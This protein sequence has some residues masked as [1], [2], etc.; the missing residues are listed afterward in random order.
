M[1]EY[2]IAHHPDFNQ[3]ILNIS[4]ISVIWENNC[5]PE[6]EAKVA[7][8][9]PKCVIRWSS[10]LVSHEYSTLSE[11]LYSIGVSLSESWYWLQYT[12]QRS[13]SQS[14][15]VICACLCG[16]LYLSTYSLIQCTIISQVISYME[17]VLPR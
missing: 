15:S 10:E 1:T 5:C 17:E 12:R 8:C 7:P 4:E 16:I 6:R 11:Y 13:L 3:L 2:Q 9:S 14:M